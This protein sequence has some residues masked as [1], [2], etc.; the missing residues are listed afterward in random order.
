MDK[1]QGKNRM[2][3]QVPLQAIVVRIYLLVFMFKFVDEATTTTLLNLVYSPVSCLWTAT[4][5][6]AK[7]ERDN[8]QFKTDLST[9]NAEISNPK[10]RM[11]SEQSVHNNRIDKLH[12]LIEKTTHSSS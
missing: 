12:S 8:A 7:L 4:A 3:N 11:L 5:Q 2:R 10:D 6:M 9:A 1:T